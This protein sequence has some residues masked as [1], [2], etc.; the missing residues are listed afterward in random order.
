MLIQASAVSLQVPYSFR[1]N[2]VC[3]YSSD[4]SLHFLSKKHKNNFITQLFVSGSSYSFNYMY[5]T[6]L[7]I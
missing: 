6:A 5:A 4:V 1:R 7:F 3:P 2:L